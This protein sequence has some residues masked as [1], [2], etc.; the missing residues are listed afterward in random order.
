MKFCAAIL[1]FALIA[2]PA[3]AARVDVTSLPPS[4]HADTEAVT[5]VA[6]GTGV[7]GDN[8]FALSLA[9]DA[10]PSNNV[11]VAFGCDADGNGIIDCHK[12]KVTA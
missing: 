9:L 1:S 3:L 2:F 5:N 7:A 6:F 12:D 11:E 4:P 10:S 8:V